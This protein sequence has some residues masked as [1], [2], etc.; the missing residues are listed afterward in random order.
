MQVMQ[1]K[2]KCRFA[3][4]G[5]L[6]FADRAGRWIHEICAVISLAVVVAGGTKSQ[7]KEQ[8]QKRVRRRPKLVLRID[9]R[10]VKR[11]QIR[12]PGVVGA[13][14]GAV[15][16]VDT[17]RPQEQ[18]RRQNLSPPGIS[19][20]RACKMPFR[21]CYRPPGHSL[22]TSPCQEQWKSQTAC[23]ASTRT[24]HASSPWSFRAFE[25]YYRTVG[26]LLQEQVREGTIASIPELLAALDT[27]VPVRQ[28][29]KIES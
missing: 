5:A 6:A 12:A 26:C 29:T 2:R 15:G 22:F 28:I 23:G 20:E 11:S 13:F 17:K 1:D 7:W 18:R 27:E 8:D 19:P 25:K 24:N 3:A 14:E 4:V 16:C 21:D 9:Q 10:R